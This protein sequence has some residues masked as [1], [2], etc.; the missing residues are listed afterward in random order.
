VADTPTRKSNLIDDLLRNQRFPEI[1]A[2][3]REQSQT[4]VER[5][6]SMVRQALPA[7]DSLTLAQVRD[8]VPQT[9]AKLADAL[10]FGSDQVRELISQ[11]G[12]HAVER[13]RQGYNVE[14]LMIEYRLLRRIVIEQV[15]SALSRRSSMAEDLALSIGI[16]TVVQQGVVAFVNRQNDLIKRASDAEAKFLAFLSH[17]LRN[18]LNHATLGLELVIRKLRDAAEYADD[19]SL[20]DSIQRSI[21]D[22]I[23]A[24]ERVLQSERLRK[25]PGEPKLGR[26]NLRDLASAV[27]NELSVKAKIKGLGLE[28]DVPPD[29][30]ITSDRQLIGL[31]LHNL[32]HNA[33]KYSSKGNVQISAQPPGEDRPGWVLSVSDEGPGIVPEHRERLFQ[34]F[35]R[36]ETY[37]QPGVGLGLSIVT[38]AAKSLGGRIIVDSQPG[39]GSTFKLILPSL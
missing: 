24:M 29:A 25:S 16:D 26:V 30:A 8:E 31:V 34:A 13:V 37:G 18:R 20:L 7:A 15:E 10:E 39:M 11:T 17:D 32:L 5:W 38:H 1:A 23:E 36:G 9:L 28:I 3:L 2:L 33:V 19:A 12:G 6:E 14:E 21:T 22:T 4:I 35:E 27:A